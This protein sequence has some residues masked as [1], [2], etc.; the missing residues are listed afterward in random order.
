MKPTEPAHVPD[1]LGGRAG[2]GRARRRSRGGAQTAPRR[3]GA[4][5]A[6]PRRPRNGRS[7]RPSWGRARPSTA[8]TRRGSSRRDRRRRPSPRSTRSRPTGVTLQV[9][10]AALSHRARELA[11][12]GDPEAIEA[13]SASR[14][15]RRPADRLRH[16]RAGQ[17][18]R[19]ADGHDRVR[20]LAVRRALRARVAASA[21]A[22][23]DADVRDRR[24]RPGAAATA[25]CC[26]RS[27]PTSATP[28]RT[29]CASCCAPCAA[30]C[31]CAG[32]STASP[33][34][35]RGPTPHNSPRNLF[36]F[37]DGT[38]NPRPNDAGADEPAR[39]G[40][41]R[42][43]RLGRRGHL[44]G[45]ADDPHARRVLGPRRP[46]RAGENDRPRRAP[47]AR[48]S[49]GTD[50][51]EDPRYELDPDG[52]RIP[53]T[54]HI[55]LANPRTAPTADQRILRRGFNYTRGFDEAG[56]LDQGLVFV[57]FNQSPERQFADRPAA[58]ADRSR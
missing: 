40:G 46:H 58:A 28:S 22:R 56:A 1:P 47:A 9:A 48:R 31:S 27:A 19:R 2:R 45:G 42:R 15:S 20:R 29:R 3:R 33:A 13:A 23:A 53:L 35:A 38:A 54:A 55:R 34:R 41:T 4:S 5:A 6:S 50:E 16:P 7:R 8:S 51:F 39:V 10:L 11:V 17:R 43:A 36:A 32:R 14:S 21:R 44:P 24:P 37:R 49:G 57:A 18:A 52:K 26:C 25:T 30:R 12:G